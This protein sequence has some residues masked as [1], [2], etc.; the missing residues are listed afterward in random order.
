MA[1]RPVAGAA[2]TVAGQPTT[3]RNDYIYENDAVLAGLLDWLEATDDPRNAG[4][5]LIDNTLVIFTSDNGAES[6]SKIATGP[7]R[8]N[9]GSCYEGGH[10]VPFIASWPAGKV[11]NGNADTPGQTRQQ[12]ICLTDVFATFAAITDTELPDN[13]AGRKGAEDSVS[14]LDSLTS[15]NT[16]H[17]PIFF[18]DHKEAKDDPAVAVLR[19]DNPTVDGATVVGQWKLFFDAGLLRSGQANPIELYDL[20]TDSKEESNRISEEQLQPL[21]AE[22]TRVA[23]KHRTVGGHRLATAAK[24]QRIT[25]AWDDQSKSSVDGH[26]VTINMAEQVKQ[27]PQTDYD[28]I[29][30]DLTLTI[31][32][33][34]S[35]R[36]RTTG[37]FSVNARGLGIA[38]GAFEQV[39]GSEAIQVSFNKDVIVESAAIIAGNG[40]CGGYYQVG[41]DKPL[42]IYC[43]DAD[44]DAKDQSGILSD[45]GVLKA[46][47]ILRLDS[48]PHHGV[49]TPG[50]WRLQSVTVR[51]LN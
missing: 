46:G 36:D 8:S 40:V 20:L 50:R 7:F 26:H 25:F 49:E 15:D 43:V 16:V 27:A 32:S 30:E 47:E 48:T 39:E 28:M 35:S 31:R 51:P 19:L 44:I 2:K 18:H 1:S 6:Q 42:A 5:K 23:M 22:L 45:I 33:S 41:K 34:H 11:G 3:R 10:R 29:F 37:N 24:E 4:H 14:F 21:V 17:R 38:G 9:K 13:A 12:L